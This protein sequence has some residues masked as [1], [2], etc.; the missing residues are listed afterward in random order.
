MTIPRGNGLSPG[1]TQSCQSAAASVK[2]RWTKVLLSI[3]PAQQHTLF[4]SRL[5]TN[6]KDYFAIN[7]NKYLDSPDIATL[8]EC[9]AWTILNP[10]RDV[11]SCWVCGGKSKVAFGL[12]GNGCGHQAFSPIPTIL[13]LSRFTKNPSFGAVLG[14][15]SHC[16]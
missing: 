14:Q 2:T 5:Q 16:I 1:S 10:S 9:C 8:A 11:H 4:A 15:Q 3:L 6:H 7:G 13:A 12:F